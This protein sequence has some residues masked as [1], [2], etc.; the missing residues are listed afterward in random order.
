[1]LGTTAS[2]DSKDIN[3]ILPPFI[4]YDQDTYRPY[5]K[6]RCHCAILNIN[7]TLIFNIPG[8]INFFW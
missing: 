3:I 5:K 7:N 2:F 4:Y 1:M 8:F 6:S